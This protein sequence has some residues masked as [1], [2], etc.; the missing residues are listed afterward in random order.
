MVLRLEVPYINRM[1]KGVSLIKWYK[2]EGEWINYGDDLL[3]LEVQIEDRSIRPLAERIKN[4]TESNRPVAENLLM[5]GETNARPVLCARITSSDIGILR[6]VYVKEGQRSNVGDLLAL[7]TTDEN[8]SFDN[9]G[10]A[11]TQTGVFRVV[12]NIIF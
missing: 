5:G 9:A 6:K 1:A 4:L 7:I 10:F 2:A 8:E 3:D 11:L 12:S